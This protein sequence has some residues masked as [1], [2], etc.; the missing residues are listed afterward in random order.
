[1]RN[2]QN[3]VLMPRAAPPREKRRRIFASPLWLP[4][5]LETESLLREALHGTSSTSLHL[6]EANSGWRQAEWVGG[7]IFY[8]DTEA[9]IS[10][11]GSRWRLEYM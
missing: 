11:V 2:V 1:M 8:G 3:L 5:S 4:I 9:Q 10:D 6:C 7:W